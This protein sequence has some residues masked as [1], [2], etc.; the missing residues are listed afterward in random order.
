MKKL[1]ITTYASGYA[2]RITADDDGRPEYEIGDT[3]DEPPL[4][5]RVSP[6]LFER[7]LETVSV[8]A[9][10]DL[11]KYIRGAVPA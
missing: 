4:F 10:A 5:I 2:F 3:I 6:Q 1:E 11:A 9:L 7:A 8:G